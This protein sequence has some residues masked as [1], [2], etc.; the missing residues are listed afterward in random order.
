MDS[1]LESDVEGVLAN[2]HTRGRTDRLTRDGRG[3]NGQTLSMSVIFGSSAEKSE[4]LRV[5]KWIRTW[6]PISVHLRRKRERY[7]EKRVFG[8]FLKFFGFLARAQFVIF[9][10]CAV[11]KYFSFCIR[12]PAV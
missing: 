3:A 5:F 12:I 10:K 9:R 6:S 11:S 1:D 2:A 8:C 4:N 7:R